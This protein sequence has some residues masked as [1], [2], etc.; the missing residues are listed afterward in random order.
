MK[1]IVKYLGIFPVLFIYISCNTFPPASPNVILI[2]TD[3]QGYGD[4]ACHGNPAIQTPNLDRLHEESIRF[5]NF[6]VNCFCAPTRAALMTGRMSDRTH[7]RTTVYSRN[8]LNLDETTMAEFFK[9]SGY[10]T[11]LFGKW[12]LGLNYPYRPIDRGFDQ[13]IGY[14]DGGTGTANDYWGNDR[15]D[16]TYLYN[17]EWQKREG[18]CTDV[19]FDEA[20]EFIKDNKDRAFFVYLPTYV[21]HG[22]WNVMEE[23]RKE[24]VN[25]NEWPDSKSR[26]WDFF[27]SITRFDY[28]LGRLRD[29][30][31]KNDLDKSTILIFLTDN[32]TAGGSELYNAGMRGRKGSVYEGGHRVPCFIHWP[33]IGLTKGVDIDRFTWHFDL[34]PTLIDLCDLEIPE[35]GH[36]KFDGVSMVPLMNDKNAHWDNRLVFMHEQ[37]TIE[38]P[39]KGLNSLVATEKWRFVNGKELYDIKSDFGQKI[40]VASQN[41]DVVSKLSKDYES[42]WNE[43]KLEDNPFPRPIIGT[44]NQEIIWLTPEDWIRDSEQTHTWSQGHVLSGIINNGFWPVNI[45]KSGV[46]H[47]DVRRW[48]KELNQ[49]I[50]SGL[51]EK[52]SE[53]MTQLGELVRMPEGK[54]I[55]VTKVRLEVGNKIMEKPVNSFDVNAQFEI[56]LK[57]GNQEI[58]A[59]LIDKDGKKDGAYYIYIKRIES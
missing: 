20:M 11:G 53:K 41:Q 27:A 55:Q 37:N 33:A 38:M 9:A 10:Q 45:S 40:N 29:F 12:H 17:G 14:G 7:V 28:N 25:N 35:R 32:G 39:E 42:F 18:F 6:H 54:P 31:R 13:W 48:P 52:I 47:F 51:P 5:S 15:M 57:S 24:Y 43:I 19:F 1:R 8:H 3:D 2:M 56:N 16:D 22:P 50:T 4:L 23:W 46:Y 26:V 34:L 44:K 58:R 59:Y 49:P 36:L 30:L 21:P